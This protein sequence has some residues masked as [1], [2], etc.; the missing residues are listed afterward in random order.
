[1]CTTFKEMQI[2]AVNLFPSFSSAASFLWEE[3]VSE[4]RPFPFSN[5]S[6]LKLQITEMTKLQMKFAPLQVLQ[7]NW[8]LL[9]T[10]NAPFPFQQWLPVEITNNWND[11]ITDEVR[12]APSVAT[13]LKAASN[14]KVTRKYGLRTTHVQVISFILTG[15]LVT[16][17]AMI[18]TW[19][20]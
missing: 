3:F 8:K 20:S 14:K 9:Q 10:R 19:K 2:T 18:V 7:V 17:S 16:H 15:A 1:M 12:S 11:K 13:Q 5:D 4:L 6:Q